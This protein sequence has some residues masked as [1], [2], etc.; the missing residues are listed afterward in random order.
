[1]RMRRGSVLKLRE[2]VES[3]AC[4]R[5]E[6]MHFI[7]G[8]QEVQEEKREV[9]ETVKGFLKSMCRTRCSTVEN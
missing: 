1:M 6:E 3:R 7:L 5:V 4:V 8:F 9:M 2:S